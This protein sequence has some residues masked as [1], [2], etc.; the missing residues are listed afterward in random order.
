LLAAL[1]FCSQPLIARWTGI[2][3]PHAQPSRATV[4]AIILFQFGVAI[5]GGY[6]GAG[7]GILM[8]SA[9]AMMGLADIHVMNGLKSWLGSCINGVA[10]VVFIVGGR[11]DWP[12]A[13]AMAIAGAIGGYAGASIARRLNRDLVRRTVVVIGFSLAAY[14][15]YQQ[16]SG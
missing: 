8:L 3:R 15:F 14:F 2:G 5:Y 1:L 12:L 9:L 11:V 16:W 13:V 7:I 10:V 6:F 4:A